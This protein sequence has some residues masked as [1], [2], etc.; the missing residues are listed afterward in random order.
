MSDEALNNI[1]VT[2][3]KCS[4]SPQNRKICYM[5]IKQLKA[6]VDKIGKKN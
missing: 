4:N 6:R 2:I 5:Y 1:T 3:K